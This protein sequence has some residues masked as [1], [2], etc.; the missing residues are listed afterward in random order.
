M[1]KSIS[2]MKPKYIKNFNIEN[3]TND[4]IEVIEQ[5]KFIKG[6]P[7]HPST[8]ENFRRNEGFLLV[9]IFIKF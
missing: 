4:L 3:K 2:K 6:S 8:V 1:G 9:F 7:R 5:G